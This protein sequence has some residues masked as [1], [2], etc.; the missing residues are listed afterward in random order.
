MLNIEAKSAVKSGLV[1]AISKLVSPLS[2][3]AKVTIDG[4]GT[5]LSTAWITPFV[6][7]T[8]P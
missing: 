4:I 3:I 5:T 1:N 8:F 2:A 7:Y 6:A